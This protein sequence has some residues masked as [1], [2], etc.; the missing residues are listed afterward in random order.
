M[1]LGITGNI[2]SSIIYD[3]AKGIHKAFNNPLKL[4][5]Q[6]T[7]NHFS[8]EYGIEIST[9]VL[10][11]IIEGDVGLKEMEQFKSGIDFIQSGPLALQMALLGLPYTGEDQ[12][13]VYPLAQQV[14]NYFI[15]QFEFRLMEN[16]ETALQAI[17]SYIKIYNNKA[18]AEHE[19]II[20]EIQKLNNNIIILLDSLTPLDTRIE[21]LILVLEDRAEA[22][23]NLLISSPQFESH[24]SQFKD[25]HIKHI[26]SLKERKL[27]YAH[28]I[29]NKI[30]SIL[31][32]IEGHPSWDSKLSYSGLKY[33]NINDS[34]ISEGALATN[35]YL[36][37]NHIL[38]LTQLIEVLNRVTE[39]DQ[40]FFTYMSILK[41]AKK[42]N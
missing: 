14:M 6:D 13:E 31:C 19:Q 40:I 34:P 22:I 29:I 42:P 18:S 33:D 2:I 9:R 21:E 37:G 24:L 30:H 27:F 26:Q 17:S 23:N 3:A 7:N 35:I 20:N 39:V 4:A 41:S 38:S 12:S 10:S 36:L 16:P 15:R 28:E 5:L 25:L 8:K 32:R 11:K 1:S